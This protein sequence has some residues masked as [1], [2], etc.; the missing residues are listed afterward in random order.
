MLQWA[1]ATGFAHVVLHTTEGLMAAHVPI[2]QAGERAVRFHIAR[3]NRVFTHLDGAA[4]VA[5]IAG[6]D[7]YVTPNWYG[8][9]AN[10]VPTW[11]Y[12]AVE[13][14]GTARAIGEEAL[15]E[16][17]DALAAAHEPRV[18]PERPWTRAKMA[19]AR[20]GAML[21]AIAG[22]EIAIDTV[23][24]TRKLSQNKPPQDRACIIAGLEN[25]GRAELAETM[26]STKL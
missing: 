4:V 25:C 14:Y 20:F 17:L 2:V 5:S 8:D 22:F 15:V 19:E 6:A 24:A 1:A 10:Q 21:R 9:P 26:R 13:L 23:R 3:A 7:G 16:Q 12:V 18:S 11:N